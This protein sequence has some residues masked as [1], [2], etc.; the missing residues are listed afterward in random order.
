MGQQSIE[1]LEQD[2][3]IT[4]TFLYGK[5]TM[6]QWDFYVR[7]YHALCIKWH[8]MRGEQPIVMHGKSDYII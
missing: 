5:L 1:Q 4:L 7:Q 3:E 8:Q 6:K 2:I